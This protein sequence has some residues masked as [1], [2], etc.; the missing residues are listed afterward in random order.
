MPPIVVPELLTALLVGGVGGT[1]A[2]G[3]VIALLR[4]FS[5]PDADVNELAATVDALARTVRR[6]SMQRLRA[7]ALT[8]P[9]IDLPLPGPSAAPIAT[10]S[11][12]TQLRSRVFA[13][14]KRG[15]NGESA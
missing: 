8:P 4:R 11:L 14:L 5:R 12:K 13:H 6:I 10:P 9:P 15:G 3:V 2:A 1:I 7:G